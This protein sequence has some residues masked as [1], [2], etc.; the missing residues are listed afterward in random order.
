MVFKRKKKTIKPKS[1]EHTHDDGVKH[2]HENGDIAHEHNTK[3]KQRPERYDMVLES[4]KEVIDL[5]PKVC[6]TGYSCTNAYVI[7]QNAIK[8]LRLANY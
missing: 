1:V 4:A 8:K 2:S 3:E 7:L 5:I 6:T